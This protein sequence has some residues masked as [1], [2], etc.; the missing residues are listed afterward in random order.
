MM[1]D[2]HF[3]CFSG[4]AFEHLSVRSFLEM[5][6]YL[7]LLFHIKLVLLEKYISLKIPHA[8]TQH[9][10]TYFF[11]NTNITAARCRDFFS[12]DY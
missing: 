10:C 4:F 3:L 6:D 7:F 2:H 5:N 1:P 11:K 9:S 8:F 12:F